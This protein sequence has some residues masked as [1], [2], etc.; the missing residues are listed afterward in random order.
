ML[1]SQR[2]YPKQLRVLGTVESMKPEIQKDEDKEEN[3]TDAFLYSI[4][5]T[6]QTIS[7][8]NENKITDLV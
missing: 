3:Y 4:N 5:S 1:L 7:I 6:K 2:L 8:G